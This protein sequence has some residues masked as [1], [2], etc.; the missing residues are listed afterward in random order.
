MS[1]F[2]G[3]KVT[4]EDT[5]EE[6]YRRYVHQRQRSEVKFALQ[7]HAASIQENNRQ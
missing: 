7:I 3:N 1:I 2:L 4:T 5:P 6:K